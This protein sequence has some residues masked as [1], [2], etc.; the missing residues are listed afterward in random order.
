MITCTARG[1]EDS[2]FHLAMRVSES[3][4]LPDASAGGSESESATSTFRMPGGFPIFPTLVLQGALVLANGE[5]AELGT[6][7]NPV[8]GQVTKV[9]VTLTVLK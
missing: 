5:T 7:T 2:R 1:L 8:T 3:S 9:D 4:V 6:A